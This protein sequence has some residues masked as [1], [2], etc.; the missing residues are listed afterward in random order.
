MKYFFCPHCNKQLI[1]LNQQ[2]ITYPR[3]NTFWCDECYTTYYVDS[4][5]TYEE[6]NE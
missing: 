6:V 2:V 3:E 1:N 4:D 5:G